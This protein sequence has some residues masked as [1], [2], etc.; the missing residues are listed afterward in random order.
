MMFVLMVILLPI[1]GMT[2]KTVSAAEMN[3]SVQA[4]IP[5]NQIDKTQTYF[6]LKMTPNQEQEL[7]VTMRNDTEKEVAIEVGAN[8]AVTNDNGIVDY[9]S[10]NK[11]KDSTL[12]VG[13]KDVATVENEVT[14]PANSEQVLKIKVKMP[15]T[16]YDGVILGGIYFTE[17]ATEET[18]KESKDSQVVNTYAYTIGVKLT[19]TDAEVK[20]MLVVNGVE[21]SQVNY[22]N[23]VKA[24]IQN[25]Q[26]AIVKDLEIDGKVY[27]KG[28][29]EVLY[30]LKKDGLRMAPN[31]NFNY[32]IPTNNKEFKPGTY[33]FKGEATAGDQKWTFEKEFTIEG[34]DAKKLNSE[35]VQI[36][37]SVTW[38]YVL[39]GI[40]LLVLLLVVIVLLLLKLKKQ[41][42][43]E[44]R[45]K[46]SKKNKKKRK[47]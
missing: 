3:F 24:T 39:I 9:N 47:K 34:S 31:S 17:K 42:E 33:V 22:R 40:I 38:I 4:V 12:K 43:E 5:E 46:N 21:A 20:P 36:E 15:E 25:T 7:E 13:F 35:A 10:P 1:F 45:K 11:E 18:E 8:N 32:A 30:Q 44:D 6:D 28:E 26:A 37:K 14:I 2:E 16:S 19:E 41:K 27:A 23:T 29:K